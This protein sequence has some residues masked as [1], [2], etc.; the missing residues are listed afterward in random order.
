MNALFRKH[1]YINMHMYIHIIALYPKGKEVR[2][3]LPKYIQ[4]QSFLNYLPFVFRIV[5]LKYTMKLYHW[6]DFSH[7]MIQLYGV[8]YWLNLLVYICAIVCQMI[9]ALHMLMYI[10]LTQYQYYVAIA[11]LNE[12]V[13]PL[14]FTTFTIEKLNIFMILTLLR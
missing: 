8:F 3:F 11:L 1:A 9:S 5:V 12:N 6:R 14:W 7:P 10:A 4:Q 13:H 2:L